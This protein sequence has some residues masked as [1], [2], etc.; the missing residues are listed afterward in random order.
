MARSPRAQTVYPGQDY[1]PALTRLPELYLEEEWAVACVELNRIARGFTVCDAMVKVA[2]VELLEA[3]P[4]CPGKY[5][6]VV[7]GEVASVE[8]AYR[9]GLEAGASSVIDRLFLA[10][11][12]RQIFPAL[13]GLAKQEVSFEEGE[14]LGVIETCTAASAILA[15]DAACKAADVRLYDCHIAQG[16][17]GKG[18]LYFFGELN[19]V[20]ASVDAGGAVI[21]PAGLLVGTEVI[22]NPD[23][24]LI[25]RL[26]REVT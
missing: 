21:S 16:L 3:A 20:E 1:R 4:L 5:L 9:M 14:S 10:R 24:L 2:P 7:G 11:A 13:V 22:P 18:Y 26:L 12:D 6:I 19:A 23:A 15:A 8:S 17:G 25:E